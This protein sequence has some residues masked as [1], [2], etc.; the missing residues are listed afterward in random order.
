[1]KTLAVDC[2]LPQ[3]KE[4]DIRSR[5][6]LNLKS[7]LLWNAVRKCDKIEVKLWGEFY[8]VQ[9]S[10]DSSEKRTVLFL[11]IWNLLKK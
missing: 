9:K 7:L 8:Y 1:M 11:C 10:F 2:P 5:K 4:I 3:L 6:L